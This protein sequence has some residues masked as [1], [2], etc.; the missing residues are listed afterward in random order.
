MPGIN[1]RRQT[2]DPAMGSDGI[3]IAPPV[4]ER[5]AGVSQRCE[6]RLVQEFVPEPTVEALDEGILGRLAG[7][8]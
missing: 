8:M 4:G 5:L 2:A 3:E 1:R 7:A 6:Q